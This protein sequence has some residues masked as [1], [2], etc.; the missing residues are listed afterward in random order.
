MNLDMFVSLGLLRDCS[1][2]LLCTS[3]GLHAPK[4]EPACVLG[5]ASAARFSC[6]RN[7]SR[8][9]N[10]PTVVCELSCILFL[11]YLYLQIFIS[12][13]ARDPYSRCL[14]QPNSMRPLQGSPTFGKVSPTPSFTS[15]V[16]FNRTHN[17]GGMAR[18]GRKRDLV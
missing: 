1:T 4:E 13:H 2:V 17:P 10:T 16:I 15:R 12:E 3:E 14:P 9:Y 6:E 5:S 8:Y 7:S 18:G 11:R